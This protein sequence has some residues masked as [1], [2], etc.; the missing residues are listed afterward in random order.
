MIRKAF[1]MQVN[2]DAH[3]EYQRRHS[4]IW[5]ELEAELKAHGAHNYSIFL[6]EKRHLLFGFVEIE[7]EA[8]WNA[9]A[10]TEVCQRWWKH[11]ADVMPSNADNSP[12]TDELNEVFY[13]R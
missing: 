7:S 5:P 2:P 4:P 12:V 1:V 10:Q 6:D 13:L 11:M 3:A 8:R 9:V